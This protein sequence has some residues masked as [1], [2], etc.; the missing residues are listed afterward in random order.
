[1]TAKLIIV[2]NL[3]FNNLLLHLTLPFL[4]KSAHPKRVDLRL[5]FVF[6]ICTVHHKRH[7]GNEEAL[8]HFKRGVIYE[9]ALLF[10]LSF[11]YSY[12]K[13][14]RIKFPPAEQ[15]HSQ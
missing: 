8:L 1:M 2:I 15:L 6:A 3:C 11:D 12:R 4:R 13:T 9:T 10:F 7:P 5:T 14:I